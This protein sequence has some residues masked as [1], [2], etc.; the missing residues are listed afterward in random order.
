[1]NKN[2]CCV[3]GLV[4]S[5]VGLAHDR[6]MLPSHTI[7]SGRDGQVSLIASIS[8]D[9]FHP[10][11]PLG[12]DGQ[13]KVSPRLKTLFASLQSQ[14]ILPDGKQVKGSPWRAYHRFSAAD[15]QLEMAGTYRLGLVQESTPMVTF[16]RADGQHGRLFGADA[17]LPDGASDVHRTTT[18]SR[19]ETFVTLDQPT[20]ASWK[21]TGVG[22]EL[23]GPSHPND[24]FVNESISWRLT[25]DGK[26]V[27]KDVEVTLVREDTRHRNQ[28]EPIAA[29]TDADG[30]FQVRFNHPG[31]Y[32][33]KASLARPGE[34]GSGFEKHYYSLYVTVEVFPE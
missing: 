24:L 18:S 13:S 15:Q 20:T 32:L 14:V 1:M 22:L 23:S 4:L 8:N 19:V 26:P 2:V 11:M 30:A 5:L 12:D 3:L 34:A 10:D 9:V 28:R 6:Y 27:G 21:P 16:K 17:T 33:L 29:K 7:L 25:Y 31:F